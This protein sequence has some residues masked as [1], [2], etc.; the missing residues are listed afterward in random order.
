MEPEKTEKSLK[1]ADASGK[2]YTDED[3][4]GHYDY[5]ERHQKFHAFWRPIVGGMTFGLGGAMLVLAAVFGWTFH[6]MH[7]G[8]TIFIW[9]MIIGAIILLIGIAWTS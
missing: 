3:L 9:G 2:N 8:D 5:S 1:G 4:K 7:Q 6:M